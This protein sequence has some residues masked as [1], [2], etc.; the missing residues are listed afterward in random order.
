MRA[1]RVEEGG[2]DA[3]ARHRHPQQD[4]DPTVLAIFNRQVRFHKRVRGIC[5]IQSNK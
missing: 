1:Q 3:A 5:S 2:F 4:P